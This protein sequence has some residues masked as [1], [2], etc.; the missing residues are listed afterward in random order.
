MSTRPTW[1]EISLPQLAEN[2]RVI[3]ER[4]GAKRAVMAIVKAD[5]YGHGLLEI[6]KTL[7]G[8]GVD[9]FGVT[10]ADEG[11]ELRQIGISQPILLLTGFWEGEQQALTDFD[12]VPAVYS[13]DQ[14]LALESWGQKT[15]KRIRFHLKVNTGMGRLGIYWQEV[16]LFVE[17]YRRMVHVEIEGLFAQFSAA[18]DFTTR[19][20]EEQAERFH[21][22]QQALAR[23]GIFPRYCHQANSA[24]IVNRPE[25][26]GNMVRP[27]LLLYGYQLPPRF[28]AG[29][30]P[31]SCHPLPVRE[32]LT[33]KSKIIA[34]KE[35]PAGIALGYGGRYVTARPSRIA[36]IPAGYADGLDRRLS[37]RGHVIVCG[38]YSPI[39]GNISMDLTL[40]DGTE[41]PHLSVGEEA[42]LI[43]HKGACAVTALD[44]AEMAGTI[45]YEI[46]CGIGKRVP[47]RYLR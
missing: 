34:V 23:A 24:A 43:G 15:G 39:V 31:T 30:Q 22:V 37:G 21:H 19:Q 17:A 16:E 40:L 44:L 7:A 13:E 42:I 18:E 2:Y 1:V 20:T 14:L 27:G 45:P 3:R 41:L 35:V 4:V 8:L 38:Q 25:T 26:W 46:L 29:D 36:T 10:S 11:I 5:A 6:S 9:W 28:P 32:I 12:L 47:R 33:F